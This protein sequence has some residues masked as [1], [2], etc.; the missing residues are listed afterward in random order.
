MENNTK[1]IITIRKNNY[2]RAYSEFEKLMTKTQNILNVDAKKNPS[3]Y[4]KMK[5]DELEYHSTDVL[6]RACVDTPFRP[7]EIVLVSGHNFP[8]IIAEKYYGIEVK[9]TKS[10]HWTSTGSS[11]L[12]S[13]RVENVD[14]IFMLFG[15]L[16]GKVP[17]FMCRPY[18]DVLYDI[19]VTHSPRY[20]INMTLEE[21]ETI[22]DKMG[23]DY[24]D[25]RTS[26][27]TIEKARHYYKEKAE[28]ENKQVMLWWIT[29]DDVDRPHSFVIKLWNSL[30]DYEKID[31]MCKSMIL[32]PETLNPKSS[33]TKYNRTTLWL[34]SYCQVVMPNI[35]DVFSAGGS[36]THV[37]NRKLVSPIPNVFHRIVHYAPMIERMLSKPS[38]EL[39]ALIEEHNPDLLLGKKYYGNWLECCETYAEDYDI[40]LLKWIEKQ[41]KFEFSRR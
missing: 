20:L 3:F 12:E 11:I 27:N 9:S 2:S 35:R 7:N 17:E 32:F 10:N 13:T 1:S 6:K 36:I 37:N 30:E 15:K 22:F 24:D 28:K 26:D 18:Q 19:A 8:D 38:K 16:G 21:G 40:P 34:C 31:L 39:L 29:S 4:K 5:A 33:Q 25:F 23:I 14:D 41:P